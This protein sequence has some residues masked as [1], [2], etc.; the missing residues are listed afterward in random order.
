MS[1]K[2]PLQDRDLDLL[3]PLGVLGVL[4]GIDVALPPRL[5]VSGSFAIAAVVASAITTVR[6]TAMVGL[7][8]LVVTAV[9]PIW[10]HDLNTAGWWIRLAMA[11]GLGALAVILATVR[12]RREAALQ[13]MTT[14]AEAAQHALLRVIPSSIGSLSFA[15]RYVSATKEALVGGDLYE[16]VESPNGVR[17]IVGD[18]R[19]KGLDAV[20][21]AATVLATFRRAAVLELPLTEIATDLDNVVS[22]VGGMEDFVTALLADLH[23]DHT[24]TLV[25][26][27]HHPPLLMTKGGASVLV[28]T[29]DPQPPLGLNP[30]PNPVTTELP[31]GA[32]MLF[33]T[34]GMIETRDR[35]GE[36]FP[37]TDRADTLRSETLDDALDG[38]LGQVAD[39][40]AEE[41]DDDMALV[42]AER[43]TRRAAA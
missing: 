36:F 25:N 5:L 11:V 22:A 14:I 41:I 4:A 39:H 13:H 31:D 37:L 1:T 19:G 34:D 29:G 23:D 20:Q 15:T 16:V 35:Q 8:A 21:M 6:R 28:D 26:C 3:I 33:Y 9:S 18:A 38:L 7:A 43:H 17:L 27:G 30:T 40:A 42:L 24:V 12:V 32:R 10:N 2:H